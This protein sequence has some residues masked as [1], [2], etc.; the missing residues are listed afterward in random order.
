MQKSRF[1]K[2]YERGG[3]CSKANDKIYCKSQ[4]VKA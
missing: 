1:W 2:A 3:K 4:E